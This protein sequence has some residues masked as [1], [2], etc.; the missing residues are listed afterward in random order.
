MKY[1]F[2]IENKKYLAKQSS[3]D[4]LE[5]EV[6]VNSDNNHL[7]D[8]TTLH[9]GKTGRFIDEGS[10]NQE[11]LSSKVD[12]MLQDK[13]EISRKREETGNSY[14]KVSGDAGKSKVESIEGL[15]VEER[16]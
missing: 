13:I 6:S 5:V 4:F 2:E 12:E 10:L 11:K 3:R 9:I 7:P 14:D 16:K 1:N 8:N 15:D